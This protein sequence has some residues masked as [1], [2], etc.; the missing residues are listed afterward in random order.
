MASAKIA[1]LCETIL[2]TTPGVI[3]ISTMTGKLEHIPAINTNTLSNAF[4]QSMQRKPDNVICRDC[5]SW[6]MLEGFRKT[7]VPAF[8]HNT[9]LLTERMHWDDLPRLHHLRVRF[10]AHGELINFDH[11]LN[12]HDTARKNPDVTCSIWTK[13][14]DIINRYNAE[15]T[16]P[17]NFILIYSNPIK[18]NVMEVPPEGFQK[19]FNT[20][21]QDDTRENCFGKCINC[22]MCYEVTNTEVCIV[23]T[24][25]NY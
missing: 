10:H 21:T 17:D 12:F 4:C 20:I 3:H 6:Q 14:K 8:E 11:Q 5:Y 15:Y 1:E 7:C 9:E 18:D 23:E 13:R 19:V 16:R 25:K 24:V 2:M 22:L